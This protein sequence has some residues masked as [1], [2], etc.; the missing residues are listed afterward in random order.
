M[1]RQSPSVWECLRIRSL[2]PFVLRY[3]AAIQP[4][5][6]GRTRVLDIPAGDGVLSVPLASAGF[7][8]TPADLFPEYFTR[9][10]E[11]HAGQ[12][13]NEVFAHLT[14]GTVPRAV[15][16]ALFGERTDN[17]PW[18]EKL[19]PV[20][21]DMQDRLPFDDG[22]F[23]IVLSAEGIEHMVDRHQ[24]LSEF[25]RVLKTGGKMLMTTPNVLSLRGRLSYM[26]AGTRAFKSHIDEYT[27]VWGVSEDGERTYH[28]HAFLVSYHQVRYSL[29]H[30][31]FRL[32]RV[33]RSNF[34]PTSVALWPLAPLVA[35]GTALSQYHA[36]RIFDKVKADRQIDLHIAPPYFEMFR[37]LLSPAMLYNATLIVE[38]E[39]VEDDPGIRRT[40]RAKHGHTT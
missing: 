33:L 5:Q 11:K 3:F 36:K 7:D 29:H 34:S 35:L 12:P 37:H 27:S 25:R 1:L 4:E 8:V 22:A 17:P 30:C 2:Y 18:P 31:G 40:H 23:D 6:R 26:L 15:T 9:T 19:E 28:G 20:A 38:A 39:A 16:E 10:L 21:A 24:T 14:K 13:M 32:R